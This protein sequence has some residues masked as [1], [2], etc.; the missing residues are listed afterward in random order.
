LGLLGDVVEVEDE[1]FLASSLVVARAI[2]F[3][4]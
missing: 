2:V 1:F 4:N 3:K